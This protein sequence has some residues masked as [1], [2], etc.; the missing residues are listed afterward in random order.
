MFLLLIL[1]ILVSGFLVC[2]IHPFYRYKVHR[3]EGQ[4]LYLKSA[5]LGMICLFIAL[6]LVLIV[7]RYAYFFAAITHVAPIKWLP[8]ALLAQTPYE[9]T[10]NLLYELD[11]F[12]NQEVINLT[13]VTMITFSMLLVPVFWSLLAYI[14]YCIRY[15][16]F[17][18]KERLNARVFS[19][20]SLDDFLFKSALE[21]GDKMV[22]LTLSD[23]RLYVGKVLS[24]GEPNEAE[25]LNQEI[26]IK[27]VLSGYRDKGTLEVHFTKH[28]A[29]T[30]A[31]AVT[32]IKQDLISSACAFSFATYEKLHR[33]G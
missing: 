10:S 27:P 32:I 16:T 4:Y 15:M 7:N 6:G 14:K 17:S 9:F 18:P 23:R 21:K 5:N 19:D 8:D 11:A 20:S 28:Y 2:H 30:D 22:M 24:L 25:G 13:W 31:N 1:P 3:Y 33:K 29:N 12:T 26:S